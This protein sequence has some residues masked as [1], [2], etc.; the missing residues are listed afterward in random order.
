MS[1]SGADKR[2]AFTPQIGQFESGDDQRR[3]RS[4]PAAFTSRGLRSRVGAPPT[5]GAPPGRPLSSNDG[6]TGIDEAV[7]ANSASGTRS[8]VRLRRGPPQR[9]QAVRGRAALHVPIVSDIKDPYINNYLA[10]KITQ[11]KLTHSTYVKKVLVPYINYVCRGL[12]SSINSTYNEDDRGKLK[13]IIDLLIGDA[14]YQK[15]EGAA[16]ERH[17]RQLRISFEQEGFSI[18][19]INDI[20][21]YINDFYES[22]GENPER[23]HPE[24]LSTDTYNTGLFLMS[25]AATAAWIA[26]RTDMKAAW[27]ASCVSATLG[28]SCVSATTTAKDVANG[29]YSVV[30]S[31]GLAQSNPYHPSDKGL[32]K[33]AGYGLESILEGHQAIVRGIIL[34]TFATVLSAGSRAVKSIMPAAGG[35]IEAYESAHTRIVNAYEINKPDG[36]TNGIQAI[37][38]RIGAGFSAL[39]GLLQPVRD[40]LR[41]EGDEFATRLLKAFGE[42]G[43]WL[44]IDDLRLKCDTLEDVFDYALSRTEN[45][46][47]PEELD[48]W[49]NRKEPLDKTRDMSPE[50]LE[51]HIEQKCTSETSKQLLTALKEFKNRGVATVNEF[52]DRYILKADLSDGT[53]TFAHGPMYAGAFNV[54]SSLLG[55]GNPD[56]LT[57]AT[58]RS[59]FKNLGPAHFAAHKGGVNGIIV[60]ITD[61]I[62]A[63]PVGTAFAN[64][65]YMRPS[66][67]LLPKS[68]HAR[69]AHGTISLGKALNKNMGARI[70]KHAMFP[71]SVVSIAMIL[72]NYSIE[73]A[74]KVGGILTLAQAVISGI[75]VQ[76]GFHRDDVKAGRAGLAH[77]LLRSDLPKA[78]DSL[79]KSDGAWLAEVGQKTIRSPFG[80]GLLSLVLGAVGANLGTKF[81][82]STEGTELL[83]A[84]IGGGFAGALLGPPILTTALTAARADERPEDTSILKNIASK[85][86]AFPRELFK[87]L[88][89]ASQDGVLNAIAASEIAN[90]ALAGLAGGFV[91]YGLIRLSFMQVGLA[92]DLK[93][94]GISDI[95]IQEVLTYLKESG[96]KPDIILSLKSKL[97]ET[98]I[99]GK[100]VEEVVKTAHKLYKEGAVVE[101][102]AALLVNVASLFGWTGY[103]GIGGFAPPGRW[104]AFADYRHNVA[105][106]FRTAVGLPTTEMVAESDQRR[107]GRIN[108]ADTTLIDGLIIDSADVDSDFGNGLSGRRERFDPS[109]TVTIDITADIEALDEA[110]FIER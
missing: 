64:Q 16:H 50:Q 84:T 105:N 76:W 55:F 103:T 74:V 48:D 94:L 51:I 5:S 53:A 98:N 21:S 33:R 61:R 20:N 85:T 35:E 93:E 15:I 34:N 104:Q 99:N 75:S 83:W 18:H 12:D 8:E 79:E 9:Q 58:G 77:F 30:K 13:K 24:S 44:D 89:P 88:R 41:A 81:S 110:R 2:G 59:T 80:G 23:E 54:N 101:R 42:P 27:I 1:I 25:T 70:L 39:G 100:A 37:M 62:T 86:I 82:G 108:A 65:Y 10:R 38:G 95:K 67:H 107:S 45:P 66:N 106:Q 36:E 56:I 97:E 69:N 109:N 3:I 60:A 90:L 102:I 96:P 26:Y 29:L 52:A 19:T 4:D 57:K 32:L 11:N 63:P 47:S 17:S 46:L 7:V 78:L 43:S 49:F 31:V 68:M 72:A 92:K 28:G 91:T 6:L 22:G 71:G 40:G 73:K 14:A 87:N